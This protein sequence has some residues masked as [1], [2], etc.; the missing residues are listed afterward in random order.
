MLS[1]FE[2]E[3]CQTKFVV[4][5]K[6]VRSTFLPLPP[7]FP[8][9]H[10]VVCGSKDLKYLGSSD[11]DLRTW[12]TLC[13]CCGQFQP[14]EPAKT[15]KEFVDGLEEIERQLTQPEDIKGLTPARETIRRENLN[16]LRLNLVSEIVKRLVKE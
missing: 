16:E 5:L 13:P 7:S 11:A 8:V 3:T 15:L 9:Q 6:N 4:A 2:C 12:D 1:E 10:C 14:T